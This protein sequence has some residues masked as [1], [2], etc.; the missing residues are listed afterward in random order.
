MKVLA[1]RV[2]GKRPKKVQLSAMDYMDELISS[3]TPMPK[4]SDYLAF[5]KAACPDQSEKRVAIAWNMI[6]QR[7]GDAKEDAF[8]DEDH[9]VNID[10]LISALNETPEIDE[11]VALTATT[12]AAATSL[13]L[14]SSSP[15]P[16]KAAAP[17]VI[18]P[19]ARSS[20]TT[21]S[22]SSSSGGSSS[23]SGNSSSSGGSSSHP[24][25]GQIIA[26][27][28]LFKDNFHQFQGV[29]WSLSS[30]AVIDDRL[31]EAITDMSHES[32][33]HSFVIQDVDAVLA[34]FQAEMDQEEIASA[35]VAPQGKGLL[36]LSEDEL[37]FLAQFNMP[38]DELVEFM[39]D[40]SWR[41]VAT[42]LE[43]KPSAEFQK[44][45]YNC[46]AHVL[47]T[48]ESYG[49]SLPSSPL[50][51]WCTHGLWGFLNRALH[52]HQVLEYSFG[53]V[54]SEASAHRRQKQRPWQGRQ[55]VGHKV[56]GMVGLPARSL[57][58]FYMEAG[59]KDSGAK[60]TKCLHDIRKLC[61]LMKDAHDAIRERTTANVRE[62]V[63]T[64]GLRISRTSATVFTLHQLP[65][66]FYQAIPEV[67]LS[68]PFVWMQHDTQTII[69]VITWI[70]RLRKTV[71]SM[72]ERIFKWT[73]EPKNGQR[74]KDHDHMALTMTSPQLLP[75]SLPTVNED[76]PPLDD[77]AS[78]SL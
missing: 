25:A 41:G 30:G 73:S 53:E 35:M 37:G 31:F 62:E 77:E 22:R 56:D 67:D 50:E 32:A 21:I 61:K 69:S 5:M 60:S 8:P 33:L 76:I 52:Q 71:L 6:K 36:E 47:G 2:F 34:L 16:L 75:T 1:Y 68:L 19:S 65:G 23:N 42:P 11:S 72:A 55:Q 29:P 4:T 15:S 64:F 27:K 48:Y 51:S 78:L 3:S 7:L 20:K 38:R 45:A 54:H 63:V 12:D 57:E 14:P 46:V 44:V 26:M 66:R 40:H 58:I 9:L 70:L 18:T 28:A 13:P 49:F 24:S 10:A 59:K 39:A 74:L 17:K 43:H